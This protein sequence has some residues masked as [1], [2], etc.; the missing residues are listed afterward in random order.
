MNVEL[1]GENNTRIKCLESR[2]QHDYDKQCISIALTL[3][4]RVLLK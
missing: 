4:Q 3:S 2:E 1:M